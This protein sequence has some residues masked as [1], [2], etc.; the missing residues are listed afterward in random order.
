MMVVL[1]GWAILFCI[2]ITI[3]SIKEFRR[4]IRE[5]IGLE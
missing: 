5:L 1:F 2:E 3:V 4:I